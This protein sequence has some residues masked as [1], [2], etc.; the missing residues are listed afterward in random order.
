M[1][2]ELTNKERISG[3][4]KKGSD[5]PVDAGALFSDSEVFS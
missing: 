2:L 1:E 3:K 5:M 4:T